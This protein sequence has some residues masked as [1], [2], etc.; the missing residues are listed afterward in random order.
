M[1]QINI[2]TEYFVNWKRFYVVRTYFTYENIRIL[3]FSYKKIKRASSHVLFY[4][5]KVV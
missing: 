3:T 1:E 4:P 5:N 2:K